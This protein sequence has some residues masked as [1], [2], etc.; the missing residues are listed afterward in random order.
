MDWLSALNRSL[1]EIEK[2]LEGEL[3]L[4]KVAR[5]AGCSVYHYQRIFS[6]LSGMSLSEYL[7]RRRMTLA[8]QYLRMG[9]K[10]LDTALR[11]GYE[12]PTAFN[13]AFQA[14]HGVAPSEAKKEGV[15][16]KA[17]PRLY[18]QITIKGAEQMEYRME[19]KPAFQVVGIGRVVGASMEDNAEIIPQ[20][21]SEAV[22][23]GVVARLSEII[24]RSDQYPNGILG[25]CGMMNNEWKYY[26]AVAS[27]P[28]Q[29]VPKEMEKYD[30]PESDWAVFSGTGKMPEAIRELEQ[31]IFAEWLP[32]SG[33]EYADAP[34]IEAYLTPNPEN[35]AFEVWLPIRKR[36]QA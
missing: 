35:A 26:I 11:Y 1:D 25:V 29:D 17:Y 15:S 8:A 33:Y 3:D 2:H 6:Y 36:E 30:V 18:F 24:T 10:V 13:R 32:S 16:L 20:M 7:R 19:H 22:T 12:S 27:Q 34:D 28:S 31:R 21:W 14:V 23:T 5:M 4:A 9:E